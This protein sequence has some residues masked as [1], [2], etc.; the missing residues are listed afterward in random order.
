MIHLFKKSPNSSQAHINDFLY[1]PRNLYK[2]FGIILT[3][4]TVFGLGACNLPN[5]AIDEVPT[6]VEES[7]QIKLP[8][9]L[10][11]FRVQIPENTPPDEPIVLSILDEVTGLAL[12]AKRYTM[13]AE[14]D[15]RYSLQISLPVGTIV[16][17]RYSRM[18]NLIGEEHTPDGRPVRYRLYSVQASGEINDIVTRWNDTLYNGPNG[19]IVGRVLDSK[20]N[21]P[22]PNI[23]VS[24]GGVQT[25]TDANGGFVIEGLPIGIHNLVAYSLDGSYQVFQQG[26]EVASESTT[27]ASVQ[28]KSMS[29]V[30]VT[31]IVSV[32]TGTVPGVPLRLAGNLYQLGN[33]FANLA[34][35]INSL[36]SRMPVLSPLPDGRYGLIIAL[37]SGFDLRYKYTLG[38]G[39]WNAERTDKG[40]IAVRQLIVPDGPIVIEDQ[41]FSWSSGDIAPIT[42]DVSV[43]ENTPAT[44]NVSIQFN[45]YGWTQPLP[46]WKLQENRWVYILFSPLDFVNQIGYRYCRVDQ[47]G[48]ADDLRTPGEFSSGQIVKP[49]GQPQTIQ[50]RIENWAWLESDIQPA[51]VPNI[52][53]QKRDEDFIA[54]IEMQSRYRPSWG[55]RYP[56]AFNDLTNLNA[57]WVVLT[58]SWTYTQSNPPVI[59]LVPG[60]DPMWEELIS[61]I[62]Q[63]KARELEVALRP[64]PNFPTNVDEWWANATR[65]FSWWVSWYDSNQRFVL[66]HADLAA[67]LDVKTL[68]LGGNWLKPALPGGTLADGSPTGVPADAEDRW[69]ELIDQV[70]ERFDGNI[71]WA[72]PYP[73]QNSEDLAFLDAVDQIYLLWS[74]PLAEKPDVSQADL[75]TEAIRLVEKEIQ[76]TWKKWDK[77]M[78]IS[79]AYPSASGGI[80]GCLP[81]PIDECISPDSLDYPAPDIPIIELDLQEQA[82][83]YNAV[84]TA[85]NETNWISGVVSRGYYPPAILHDKSISIQNKPA[86][87]V[88]GYWFSEFIGVPEP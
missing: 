57:N 73:D 71:A 53:I 23:M 4:I 68:I 22:V 67:E 52:N 74:A 24:A 7:S 38:D 61:Q 19:R 51:S 64:I 29:L 25:F 86:A 14:S 44:E 21:N 32:P 56:A 48:D 17:Y 55:I 42:F 79:I 11:T 35:G 63:A 88:L 31:F 12:N 13:E 16:K 28:I 65:D 72:I 27:N 81:D 10:I 1:M 8:E 26:A 6:A 39:F 66:H 15:G 33:A 87:G 77:P 78:I 82:A 43:P 49:G 36:T 3:L 47:C 85:I 46:M 45:P 58:P 84:L 69:R 70:R 76:D 5:R 18:G 60:Y 34:G 50:D 62:S 83:A 59:E 54:G 80:T 9:S 30:D 75:N 40:G 37:P 41:I 2:F 20:D